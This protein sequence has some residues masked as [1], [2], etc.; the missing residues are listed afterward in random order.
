MS[1]LRGACRFA[2]TPTGN[3]HIG[4]VRTALLS[5]LWARREGLRNVL[6]I[7]DLD[8][9]AIPPGCLEGQ[10][11]DLDWLGL[12]HDEDPRC[13]GPRA[14]YRQSERAR[15]YRDALAA[16]DATGVL[17][18]CW[19]SR[20][21]VARAATAPHASDEG[22]VYPGTCRPARP[23]TLG[24]LNALPERLGRKP[25][26]RLDVTA[27]LHQLGLDRIEFVDVVSGPQRFDVIERMGDFVVR[28]VDGIAAYQLAC[29]WDDATMGCTHVLRGCDLLA[30]T[31]RQLLILRLLGQPEPAYA[32]VGLVTS[33]AGVRL[34]KRDGSIA[35]RSFRH[36]AAGAEPL[37]A[38]LAKSAGLP[39]TGDLER[40]A[41]A[42][43][44]TKLDAGPV[45]W[46]G[47]LADPANVLDR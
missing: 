28:R 22:P 42:F 39:A 19:C 3:L 26:L 23:I 40:L 14:P 8:P 16:L 5:W 9:Q 24:D 38:A 2:P 27:A 43:D 20:K 33:A 47:P 41:D 11:A 30:S 45:V 36:N 25:A 37:R 15:A 7:E 34:A 13:G 46:A 31:A 21:E 32:H 12:H 18:P 35:I 6:R 44:V 17:Y 1:L 4:N 10:Y 29:A